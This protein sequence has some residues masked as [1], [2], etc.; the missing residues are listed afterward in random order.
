MSW[1]GHSS[2]TD[3]SEPGFWSRW[4]KP[5]GML[6]LSGSRHQNPWYQCR[7][8][9]VP[10]LAQL[11]TLMIPHRQGPQSPWDSPHSVTQGCL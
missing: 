10:H 6:G 1:R 9:P 8:Y 3:H 11:M 5:S 7:F 4:Q 2:P